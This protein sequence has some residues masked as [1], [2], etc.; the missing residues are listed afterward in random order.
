M[1]LPHSVACAPLPGIWRLW[2]G[3]LGWEQAWAPLPQPIAQCS[4]PRHLHSPG[5]RALAYHRAWDKT[6][7]RAPLTAATMAE[8]E[9]TSQPLVGW[10]GWPGEPVSSCSKSG[11]P[12]GGEK[13][14]ASCP[15][16]SWLSYSSEAQAI[17]GSSP[18]LPLRERD[19]PQPAGLL[20]LFLG[21]WGRS[22]WCAG[23]SPV[24]KR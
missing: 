20:P 9:E 19:T 2:A 13:E 15:R 4:L 22:V 23:A 21:R 12:R 14:V 5:P 3:R 24:R 17:T 8:W 16:R 11:A 18:S 6:Q 7:N 1:P 10:W